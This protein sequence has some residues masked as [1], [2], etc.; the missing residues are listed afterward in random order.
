MYTESFL[1]SIVITGKLDGQIRPLFLHEPETR[2][3]SAFR[4]GLA[5][6]NIH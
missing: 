3:S 5:F 2:G 4:M 6:I 1:V